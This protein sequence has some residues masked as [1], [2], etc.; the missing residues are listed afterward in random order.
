MNN[1]L[2]LITIFSILACPGAYADKNK[3]GGKVRVVHITD[4]HITPKIARLETTDAKVLILTKYAPSDLKAQ[5]L[6]A[7]SLLIPSEWASKRNVTLRVRAPKS[8]DAYDIVLNV[9]LMNLGRSQLKGYENYNTF[10]F[11]IR[12]DFFRHS[13]FV[14]QDDKGLINLHC[15]KKSG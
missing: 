6:V 11:I 4:H 14:F 13:V 12:G 2:K 8:K 7:G 10:D 15:H 5:D 9:A 3:S 1:L